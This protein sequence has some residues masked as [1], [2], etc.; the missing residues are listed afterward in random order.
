[1]HRI[2][3]LSTFSQRSGLVHAVIETPRGSRAK[4]KYEPKLGLFTLHRPW[5]LVSPTPSPLA[6][7][8]ALWR[9]MAIR[10]T[11]CC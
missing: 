5:A 8:P 3:E 10:W 9:A 6:S 4:F 7:S 1:M 11:S 2:D